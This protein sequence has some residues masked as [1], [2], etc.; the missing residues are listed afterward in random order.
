AKPRQFGPEARGLKMQRHCFGGLACRLK[1]A[2]D[3]AILELEMQAARISAGSML[4]DL[5]TLDQ[6]HPRPVTRDHP[7]GGTAQK[8]PADDDGIEMPSHHS[9]RVSM[10]SECS[11]S[12]TR[13]TSASVN[14]RS[15]SRTKPA[16]TPRSLRAV[17]MIA[18]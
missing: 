7:S 17:F 6:Q 18:C 4:V 1:A 15:G 2:F 8:A 5:V 3:H 14:S 12:A 16:G 11:V 10:P 13:R 9:G